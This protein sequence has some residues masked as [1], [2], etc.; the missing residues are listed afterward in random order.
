MKKI[1]S[2]FAICIFTISSFAQQTILAE[3]APNST[4]TPGGAG[5]FGPSP[6]APT[7][8]N[9]NLTIVGL[10]RGSG[11]VIPASGSGAASAWGGTDLISTD[12]ASAITEGDYATFSITANTGSTVSISGIDTYNVRRSLTGPTSGQWQ[13]QVGTGAFNN[14]GSIITWGTTTNGGGNEQPAINLSTITDLQNVPAGTTIT[15]RVLGFGGSNTGGTWYLVNANSAATSKTL[16]VRGSVQASTLAVS[17][18]K[19][20]KSAN[21]V[22]NTFVKNNEIT[23]GADVK[24]VKIFNMLG[25]V[26]KKASVRS[27]ETINVSDLVSGDYIVTGTINNQPVSQKILKD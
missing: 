21:F 22:R 12:I 13:Y 25:Q 24:D 8:A 6:F 7:T 18:V 3:W 1:Y 10:T 5:N 14:I 2:L 11:Y 17:D 26:V 27:N 4:N 19:N 16:T 20:T 9:T 23:F 15:F